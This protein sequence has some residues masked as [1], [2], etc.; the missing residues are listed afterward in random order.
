[1]WCVHLKLQ[2]WPSRQAEVCM[3]DYAC[4]ANQ[5]AAL[6]DN[7]APIPRDATSSP[8]TN[9]YHCISR[10]HSTKH[11]APAPHDDGFMHP[12]PTMAWM[13]FDDDNNEDDDGGGNRFDT[14][15]SHHTKRFSLNPLPKSCHV[16][17]RPWHIV[18]S[19]TLFPWHIVSSRTL[20]PWHIVSSS[21][22]FPWHIL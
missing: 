8:M 15:T 18:S 22:F 14:I 9:R 12:F 13:P 2:E 1:M 3:L 20:F 4:N 19:R 5:H 16:V 11:P 21:T 6:Y 10:R 17:A 7:W